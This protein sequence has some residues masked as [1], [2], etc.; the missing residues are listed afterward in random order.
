VR[1]PYGDPIS[2]KY[3]DVPSMPAGGVPATGAL[4][5]DVTGMVH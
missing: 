4:E 5:P 1:G 3:S 2:F